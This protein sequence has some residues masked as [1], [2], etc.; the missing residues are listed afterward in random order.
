M[1][2]EEFLVRCSQVG[3]KLDRIAELTADM[4]VR[5]TAVSCNPAFLRLM[6]EQHRLILVADELLAQLEASLSLE[7][8][9]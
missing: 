2:Y 5:R 8:E 6:Q 7:S 3:E 4:A 1:D 9:P